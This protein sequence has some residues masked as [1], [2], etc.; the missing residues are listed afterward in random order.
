MRAH[1]LPK[2]G[3]SPLVPPR[4]M[5]AKQRGFALVVFTT[6]LAF[7]VGQ[8]D[9]TI[10]N[11]ALPR[12]AADLG[13]DVAA[14][15]WIVDAYT[16]AF[17]AF[18]LSAGTLGDSFGNRR[19]FV[20][21]LTLFALA[22]LGCALVRSGGEL[23][24]ARAL[25]GLGAAAMLP[26]SLALL[27]HAFADAPR[28]R[29]RAIGWWTAA[30]SI[31][32]AAGPVCGGLLLGMGDWRL[33]FLVNLPLCAA[34]LLCARYLPDDAAARD[35]QK[36]LDVTG[37]L[38]AT[39]ALT[40]LT[41]CAI[42]ARAAVLPPMLL[43]GA[44]A[45]ACVCALVFVAIE[46]RRAEPMIPPALFRSRAFNAA[47]GFGM[48]VN[49]TYYGTIFGLT[50]YLQR[51][52]GYSPLQAGL[53][54]LPLT[55]GFFMS[56]VASGRLSAAYGSRL[57]MLIGAV[58]DAAGFAL[59]HRVGVGT[60]YADLWLPFLLIPTGMGL[61]VPA[62]TAAVLASV[63]RQRGGTASAVLNTARQAAGALGV[64]VYGALVVGSGAAIAHGMRTIALISC[65]LLAAACVLAWAV[66]TPKEA[67]WAKA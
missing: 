57:P 67:V 50:L 63:E 9:V 2:M 45:S 31:S 35:V 66:R 59:L 51:A 17:A 8:L 19:G 56:N 24:A 20:A 14:L 30:G 27:N 26:N 48:I 10:V 41:G 4:I 23:I 46:R 44:L 39:L 58:V 15:Q 54:F 16:L 64:A 32:I 33:I 47:V 49:F 52:L 5:P 13:A 55:A 62:M 60:S 22:S 36:R 28:Q 1:A 6:S 53:A 61:A 7:V 42:E 12:I 11:V 21:G 38:V 25:Q 3:S 37:Q 65:A 40:L 43:G 18:M 29:A 34:G